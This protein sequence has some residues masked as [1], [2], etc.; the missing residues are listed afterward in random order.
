MG[1]TTAP[2]PT[3]PESAGKGVRL[4]PPTRARALEGEQVARLGTRPY[5]PR[6]AGLDA[7]E[8]GVAAPQHLRHVFP[9]EPLGEARPD[10]PVQRTTAAFRRRARGSRC[11]CR[12]RAPLA[13][14]HHP[15]HLSRGT[16]SAEP[17]PN[18]HESPDS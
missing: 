4:R 7:A 13:R 18:T 8:G 3:T 10:E 15:P 9:H 1:S 5:E 2:T 12:H 11:H 6:D 14:R 16:P 17:S